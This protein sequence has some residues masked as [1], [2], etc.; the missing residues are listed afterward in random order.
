MYL[1]EEF[2]CETAAQTLNTH[3]YFTLL[4]VSSWLQAHS[5]QLEVS[6]LWQSCTDKCTVQ[7]YSLSP[8]DSDNG[9]ANFILVCFTLCGAPGGRVFPIYDSS[10]TGTGYTVCGWCFSF[11]LQ[12][13]T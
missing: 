5:C 7:P 6:Y 1:L 4:S 11:V 13:V 10:L 8:A 3:C 9:S 12:H 2:E